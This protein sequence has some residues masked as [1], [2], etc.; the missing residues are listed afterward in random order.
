MDTLQTPNEAQNGSDESNDHD[1]AARLSSSAEPPVG[2]ASLPPDGAV[3]LG[4][5]PQAVRLWFD[6]SAEA[7]KP[8]ADGSLTSAKESARAYR[9]RAKAD[10]TRSAYRSAVRAWCAWCATHDLIPL[11][12]SPLDVAAFLAQERDRGLAA[13][14]LDLRR[15]AIHFLHRAAGCPSPT[16]DAHV[17]ETL[18]GIRREATNKGQVPAR[19]WPQR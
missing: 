16:E 13:N 5:S 3:P 2:G 19:R 12:A 18:A 8:E 9:S 15:A 7:L 11:P 10:N 17:A 1:R 6:A 4:A 14:T